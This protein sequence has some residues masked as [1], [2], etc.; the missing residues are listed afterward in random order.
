MSSTSDQPTLSVR[1]LEVAYRVRGR[2]HTVLRDL[3][4]DIGHGESFGLVGE[5]GCGKSTAAMA[6]VR[7]LASNARI[8]QGEVLA[9]GEDILKMSLARLREVRA[10]TISMVYQEPGRALN[11]SMRIESQITEVYRLTGLSQQDA[12]DAGAEM[13]RRVQIS[14]PDRVLRAYPHELSGGMQQRIIIA[15]ALASDPSLLI[16]DEPTTALDATVGAE[17]ID[18]VEELRRELGTSVLLISHNLAQVSQICDRVG[19]LYAGLLVDQGASDRVFANPNHPYTSALIACIPDRATARDGASLASIPGTLPKLGERLVGC[20][21]SDRCPLADARCRVEEPPPETIDG[22]TFRCFHHDR[23]SAVSRAGEGE[24]ARQ[25]GSVDYGAPPLL[26]VTNASK[27]YATGSTTFKAI[28]DISLDIWTGETLGIVGESGSGKSTLGRIIMGL[29]EPD[30]GGRIEHCPPQGTQRQRSAPQMVFQ[31]PDASLNR[32]HRVRYILSRSIRK[33]SAEKVPKLSQAVAD[34]ASDFSIA[35]EQL[36]KR[37][38]RLSGGQKQR[39]AIAR[40]F[41]GDPALVVCD[42]PTSALDVSVQAS[43][44]NLFMK[45]QAEQQVAYMFVTHDLGVVRYVSDRIA[46]M[47]LGRIVEVGMAED[48]LAGPHHPYTEVLLSAVPTL[49]GPQRPRIRM[50]EMPPDPHRPAAG[51]PFQ[52]RCPR[53]IGAICETDAPP[54]Q[55]IGV[56]HRVRCHHRVSDLPTAA[57]TTSIASSHPTSGDKLAAPISEPT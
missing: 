17:V 42:E 11:P 45:L 47:Y 48:V 7:H 33:L 24:A 54:F 44:L 56:N 5:S 10:K 12:R 19:V 26:T 34:L 46:V 25:S 35:A 52:A 39:V 22:R 4:F 14:A 2:E 23:V 18:I 40:S 37:P 31:N 30:S 28:E 57:E 49:S 55:S 16:L 20:P 43:V 9:S 53:K 27:T 50:A 21:Y 1:G 41:A 6:I 15:M 13:L 29:V 36:D 32:R 8:C 3:S 51:C 38:M